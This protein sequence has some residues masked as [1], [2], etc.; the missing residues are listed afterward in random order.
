MG[1]Q[2]LLSRAPP[3]FGRHI[4]VPFEAPSTRIQIISKEKKTMCSAGCFHST[5][6]FVCAAS[7]NMSLLL[8]GAMVY[9]PA[10]TV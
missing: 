9:D 10:R 2:N 4:N 3:C 7:G 8:R 6:F 5:C 1:D